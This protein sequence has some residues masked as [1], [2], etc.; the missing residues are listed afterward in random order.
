MRAVLPAI[1]LPLLCLLSGC[2]Q[3]LTADDTSAYQ[4]IATGNSAQSDDKRLQV[5]GSQSAYDDIFYRVLN[6]S[7]M[8]ETFDFNNYQVLL[9]M[10]GAQPAALTLDAVSFSAVAQ[11]VSI[12]LQPQY[13]AEGCPQ[14]AIVQQPWLLVLFPKVNKPLAITEQPQMISC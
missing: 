12:T 6:R 2:V 3:D 14:P 5:I 11:Q 1:L 7:G 10:S 8:P 13:A 4:I 9:V